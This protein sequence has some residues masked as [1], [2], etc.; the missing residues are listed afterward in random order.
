MNITKARIMLIENCLSI[1]VVLFAYLP[2]FSF[3]ISRHCDRLI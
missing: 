2:R 1:L 3:V